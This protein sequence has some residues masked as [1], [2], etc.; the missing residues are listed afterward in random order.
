MEIDRV[1][2]EDGLLIAPNF[3]NHKKGAV[4]VL[5]SKILNVA[6]V[7]FEHQW[8]GTEYI[9]FLEANGWTVLMQKKMSARITL[10]YTECTKKRNS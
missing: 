1:L 3:V 10:M 8:S 7:K 5:W 9:D 6:G 2:K 4:S